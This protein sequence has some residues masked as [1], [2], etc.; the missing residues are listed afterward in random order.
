MA[1]IRLTD[2]WLRARQE[3]GD[4]ADALVACLKVRVAKSGAK[5]F[6]AVRKLDGRP[7]RVT[8]GRY[9]AVTLAEARRRADAFA[10]A[11]DLAVVKAEPAAPAAPL[12]GGEVPLTTFLADYVADLR[13]RGR[14]Y[15]RKVEEALITGRYALAPFLAQRYGRTPAAREVSTHDLQAWMAVNHQRAPVRSSSE[16]AG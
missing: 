2:A 15:A 5:T 9:P 6:T 8:F 1:Q 3:P 13:K 4:Y 12:S 16:C 7:V 10:E 11:R 14:R